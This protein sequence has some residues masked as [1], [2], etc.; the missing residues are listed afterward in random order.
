VKPVLVTLHAH[1]DDE[2]IFTGGTIL[3]AVEA[4]WRVV[5]IVATEGDRGRSRGSGGADLRTRRRAET[6][7]AASVLG[8]ERVDFLGYGDSGYVDAPR[9]DPHARVASAR[10][11]RPGTL[12][13][14]H[15]DEV[16]ATVRRVLVE[17]GA[18]ALTSYDDNGIY[19]H[20]DHVQ[21]HEIATRSVEGTS[22]ELYESTL[23]RSALRRL[24]T[25][26][27]GRGLVPDRWPPELAE[28]LGVESGPALVTVDVSGQLDRKL[29]ALAAHS[30]QV[31]EATT[32]MGL[33]AGVFHYLLRTEWFRV[34]RRGRGRFLDMLR[35]T[36][37]IVP[38]PVA[39]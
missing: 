19:G 32:F 35:L 18:V 15:I 37:D 7:A 22:C 23:D 5:L 30:S 21:V 31:V 1:P 9:R 34:R 27:M 26:L 14:V 16:A 28:Q 10:G 17:E 24:R 3:R 8:V 4:G 38:R 12:A 13:A 25:E 11:L 6:M 33:P 39:I 29:V 20:I 36:D 2:A